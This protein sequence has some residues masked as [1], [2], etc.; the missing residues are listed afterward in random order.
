MRVQANS[1]E[2][3]AIRQLP[4]SLKNRCFS[5]EFRWILCPGR[6]NCPD[7]KSAWLGAQ[8]EDI[9]RQHCSMRVSLLAP[10]QSGKQFDRSAQP[11]DVERRR[12][13][14]IRAENDVL[15]HRQR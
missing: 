3:E 7:L 10:Q 13:S 12:E 5:A 4:E 6:A 1:G 2:I 8:I 14:W 11:C 15:G 9:L